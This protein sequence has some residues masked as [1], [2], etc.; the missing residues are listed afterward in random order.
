MKKVGIALHRCTIGVLPFHH[1]EMKVF[2]V[3]HFTISSCE[4]GCILYTIFPYWFH[5]SSVPIHFTT[6]SF[7]F[8]TIIPQFHSKETLK[9]ESEQQVIELFGSCGS[10]DSCSE[11]GVAENNRN[12]EYVEEVGKKK[13]KWKRTMKVMSKKETER[14]K[15]KG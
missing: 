1:N 8:S 12:V 15:N 6:S 3:H 2:L 11:E 4:H 10:D 5:H 9:T 7:H 13:L 14:E